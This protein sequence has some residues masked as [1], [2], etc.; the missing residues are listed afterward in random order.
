MEI[1]DPQ[2]GQVIRYS[3]LWHDEHQHGREDGSKD[4]PVA[5]IL[6][7]K[8][9]D[10]TRRV[11]VAP[12]T[13]TEPALERQA[14]ALPPP[15]AARLGLDEAPQWIIT[16]DVNLF[17]WPGPDVRPVPRRDPP[18]IAYGHLPHALTQLLIA[19]VRQHVKDRSASTASRDSET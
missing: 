10:G 17:T 5:V 15:V 14:V 12:I 13:H 3:Y 2:P 16:D 19:A 18:T 11:V 4:R 9:D 8:T 1:P 6:A 7:V